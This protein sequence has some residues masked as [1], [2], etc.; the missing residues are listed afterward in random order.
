MK[1]GYVLTGFVLLSILA[2][3]V[4]MWPLRKSGKSVWLIFLLVYMAFSGSAYYQWGG[5]RHQQQYNR[6]QKK[7]K[8]AKALLATFKSPQA[9]IDKLKARLIE[10]PESAN[11]WF[12]LARLYASQNQ[13]ELANQAY[14]KSLQLEPENQRTAVAYAE[15]LWQ[16]NQHKFDDQIRALL[17][18]VLK[19]DPNQPDALSM[20]AM[21]AYQQK[22]YQQAILYW[23][24]LLNLVPPH[25]KE[26]RA[27]QKAIAKAREMAGTVK[28]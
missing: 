8:E 2:F 6:E 13:W 16:A 7:A 23:Q 10:Q 3:L 20:L 17:Q 14:A 25:S 19:K 28:Q 27:L 5:W 9:L 18:D 4:A 24:H 11:G 21:D 1:E 12:L 22:D 26:A 15:G